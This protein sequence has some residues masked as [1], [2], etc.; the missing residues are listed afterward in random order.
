MRMTQNMCFTD[1]ES[2]TGTGPGSL[3]D[4]GLAMD[5]T[6]ALGRRRQNG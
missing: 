1:S 2:E 6:V 4:G 5:M 3:T